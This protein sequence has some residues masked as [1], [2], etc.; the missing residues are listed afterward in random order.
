MCELLFVFIFDEGV[1]FIF[2]VKEFCSGVFLIIFCFIDDG[3]IFFLVCFCWFGGR[4]FIL[5]IGISFGCFLVFFFLVFF[6]VFC[7]CL[8]LFFLFLI[9]V[10]LVIFVLFF[11]NILLFCGDF[12]VFLGVFFNRFD[13]L[14]NL[15]FFCDLLFGG[16][17]LGLF[18]FN[19]V[20]LLI[21][22]GGWSLVVFGC[23]LVDFFCSILFNFGEK[24]KYYYTDRKF[25]SKSSWYKMFYCIII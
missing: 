25:K 22:G 11:F 15:T 10:L 4:F 20:L 18:W 13:S 17:L 3:W 16:V 24:N 7:F 19:F 6:G 21:V 9:F 5:L 8:V 1:V 14:G 2:L 12:E 23:C